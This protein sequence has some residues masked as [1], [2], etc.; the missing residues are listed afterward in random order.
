MRCFKLGR[1]RASLVAQLVENPPAMQETLVWF[2]DQ[3]DPLEKGKA[4]HSSILGFPGG[5][6]GK[7][8]AW[9]V[10]D[11]GLILGLGRSPGEGNSYPLQYSGL[12]NSTD[13]IVQGVAKSWTWL[14]SFDF[15]ALHQFYGRQFFIGPEAGEWNQDDTSALHLSCIWFLVW[16]HH[17]SDRR[18]WSVAQR[19]GT[20]ALEAA[21]L[22]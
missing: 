12:E 17:W 11:I 15:T 2:L 6:A 9:N 5:S 10:G 3:E 20:S 18:Y 16:R 19:L 7:E 14:S 22:S 8:C 4:A 1:F 21:L 13:C